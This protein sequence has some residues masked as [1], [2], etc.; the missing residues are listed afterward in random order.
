MKQPPTLLPY[1]ANGKTFDGTCVL[2]VTTNKQT[3]ESCNIRHLTSTSCNRTH[4]VHVARVLPTVT[5]VIR[6]AQTALC[7]L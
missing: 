3:L 1:S 4:Q 2:P 7:W 5:A 6:D